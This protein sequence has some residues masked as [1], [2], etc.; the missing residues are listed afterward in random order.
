MDCK[1]NGG[2]VGRQCV[3]PFI[4]KGTTYS[5]CTNAGEDFYWC[6][7]K[8][9]ESGNHV[10]GE[11]GNCNSDCFAGKCKMI[12]VRMLSLNMD[13]DIGPEKILSMTISITECASDG[14]C[15][16]ETPYCQNRL[17]IGNIQYSNI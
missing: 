11:W 3:F 8:V 17:C 2:D 1:T 4:Y 14:D 12:C 6:S 5:S 13:I 16:S 10:S 15:P 7:T 9:D